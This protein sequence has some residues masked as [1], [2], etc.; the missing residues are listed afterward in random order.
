MLL[1]LM[2]M[3]RTTRLLKSAPIQSSFALFSFLISLSDAVKFSTQ[4][5]RKMSTGNGTA[6]KPWKPIR[7]GL[8]GSIGMGKS[9]IT[10][11][12]R[13]LGIPVFDADEAVHNLYSK[14]GKAVEPIREIYPNVIV[15]ETV[16][17]MELMKLVLADSSVLPT[18]ERIVHPLVIAQRYEFTERCSQAEQLLVVYDIPLLFEKF[19]EYSDVVDY[20]IVVSCDFKTQEERVLRRPNMTKEKFLSILSKQVPDEYKR[21]HANYVIYTNYSSYAEGKSQLAEILEDIVVRKEPERFNFWK[22]RIPLVPKQYGGTARKE[23]RQLFDIVMFDLDETLCPIT[24][25][26]QNALT[27]LISSMRETMPKTY[28]SFCSHSS[29][30]E[31]VF[32][33]ILKSEMSR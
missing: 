24:Y 30:D 5:L 6:F 1:P 21:E 3:L 9:T 4:Q 26:L 25:P 19:S 12:F 16:S 15:E 10:K 29:F 2:V 8:T 17:R 31:V 33:E 14:G 11:H 23:L 13:R 18:I 7:I 28:A 20:I 22:N 32:T 27:S